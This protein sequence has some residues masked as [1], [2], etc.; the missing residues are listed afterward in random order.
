MLEALVEHCSV[1]E[2][3]APEVHANRGLYGFARLPFELR[4]A[5]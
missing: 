2:A 3:G 1:L 4:S 5:A